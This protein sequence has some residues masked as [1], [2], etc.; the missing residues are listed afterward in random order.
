M[1]VSA[2]RRTDIPA[3]YAD[4]MLRRLQVG[5]AV[6]PHPRL[7]NHYS[8]VSLGRNAVDC[9][10]FWSK[11]PAPMLKRLKELEVLGY[12]FYFQFTITPYGKDIEPFLPP[13][14]QI[15][16]TF[17][18][19]SRRIGSERVVWRYDPILLSDRFS[20]ADHKEAFG[21][22]A[23][24][25]SGFTDQCV[26]SFLDI[27]RKNARCLGARGIREPTAEEVEA[28]SESFAGIAERTGFTLATCCEKWNLSHWG[29]SHASCI[30]PIRIARLLGTPIQEKKHK[31]Q[32]PECRCMESVDIGCY[33]SCANGCFYCYANASPS[34]AAAGA[35]R[36]DPHS[37]LLIGWLPENA[38]VTEKRAV[39]GKS[40]Y[41]EY[42]DRESRE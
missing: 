13:K 29:I 41:S 25:L 35:S 32:R 5:Y 36:H 7:P 18:M 22:M 3:F 16:D 38:Y 37:P 12:P 1:I 34:H 26:I 31:G 4:W 27:Y 2:S 30:D 42:N 20:I 39:T 14:Q 15:L 8:R 40:P 28:L 11:N 23:A 10:V 21:R 24:Y 9:L 6:V 33:D 19:I 17:R